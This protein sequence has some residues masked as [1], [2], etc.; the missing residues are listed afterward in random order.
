[1][2][3]PSGTDRPSPRLS[4]CTSR[5]M[6]SPPR[7][8]RLATRVESRSPVSTSPHCPARRTPGTGRYRLGRSTRHRRIRRSCTDLWRY[9]RCHW[10]AS[11]S[12]SLPRSCHLGTERSRSRPSRA[13]AWVRIGC[14]CSSRSRCMSRRCYTT[15]GKPLRCRRKRRDCTTASLL[16]SRQ[17]RNTYRW[18]TSRMR[19]CRWR[20]SRRCRRRLRLHTGRRRCTACHCLGFR[21]T[22]P[23][24]SSRSGTDPAPGSSLR[25]PAWVC[26]AHCCSKPS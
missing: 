20:C 3:G 21:H 19:H 2:T 5:H 26:T 13:R 14:R 1:M 16:H 4:V 25:W 12:R 23:E 17:R 15:S 8:R 7:G 9:T 22:S 18:Y 11:P 10:L 24:R 6:A